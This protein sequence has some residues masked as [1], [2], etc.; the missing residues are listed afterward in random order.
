MIGNE[1]RRTVKKTKQ[2]VVGFAFEINPTPLTVV[3]QLDEYDIKPAN[4]GKHLTVL[5][6][7]AGQCGGELQ[8]LGFDTIPGD[9]V[10]TFFKSTL[11]FGTQQGFRAHCAEAHGAGRHRAPFVS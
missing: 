8:H 1:A 4:G 9:S 5:K 3:K 11:V 10:A 2:A 6:Q 7:H